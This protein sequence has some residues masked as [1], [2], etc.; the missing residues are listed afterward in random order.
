MSGRPP[1]SPV[2]PRGAARGYLGRGAYPASKQTLQGLRRSPRVRPSSC[3]GRAGL[4]PASPLGK[5][6][7]PRVG[8]ASPRPPEASPPLHPALREPLCPPTSCTLTR[9]SPPRSEQSTLPPRGRSPW[10]LCG[11]LTFQD[12]DVDLWHGDG[13][14]HGGARVTAAKALG[15]RG[16]LALPVAVLF[17]AFFS[18]EGIKALQGKPSALGAGTSSLSCCQTVWCPCTGP[19]RSWAGQTVCFPWARAALALGEFWDPT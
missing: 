4:S 3:P 17:M 13:L 8:L 19:P 16:L 7:E 1:S 14:V 12:G 11:R 18:P 9:A 10:W 5:G 15:S 6:A 2:R